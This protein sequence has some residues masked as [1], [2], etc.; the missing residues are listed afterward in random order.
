[1]TSEGRRRGWKAGL[2]TLAVALLHPVED[3][4]CGPRSF[5]CAC[6]PVSS[7]GT[8]DGAICGLIGR[9]AAHHQDDV[10]DEYENMKGESLPSV[11]IHSD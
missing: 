1:M 9:V 5:C 3:F 10:A 7:F 6:H 11:D 2:S 8:K 4:L